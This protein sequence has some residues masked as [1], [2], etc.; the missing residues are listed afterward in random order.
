MRHCCKHKDN[1][2]ALAVVYR[3]PPGTVLTWSYYP[4]TTPAGVDPAYV[5]Q[6]IEWAAA[7]WSAK[8]GVVFRQ[9]LP[10]EAPRIP[11]YFGAIDGQ[12]NVLA[13]AQLPVGSAADQKTLELDPAEAWTLDMLSGVILHE[14][15]HSLG[16]E[17]APATEPDAVMSPIYDPAHS[18]LARWD[19]A[20]GVER[21]GV[22]IPVAAPAPPVPASWRP[23]AIN[24]PVAVPGSYQITG[25]IDLVA[26]ALV[27]AQLI[28]KG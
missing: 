18:T 19:V 2:G 22:P 10:G 15:G 5:V 8:C 28:Q 26:G 13:Q 25:Y 3:W 21:Y 16:I 14:L 7:A 4:A 12:W 27:Q 9:A 23:I 17:H 20:E 11:I 6:A 1:S 24:F